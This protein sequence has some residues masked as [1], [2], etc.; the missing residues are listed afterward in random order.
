M[1]CG[2]IR[3][4]QPLRFYVESNFGHFEAPKTAILTIWAALNFEFLHIFDIFKCEI[5][6][7]SKFKAFK[8]VSMTVFDT[9]KSDNIDFT[10]NQICKKI[11]IPTYFHIV[12]YPQSKF[13]IRLLRS[14]GSVKKTLKYFFQNLKRFWI[15]SLF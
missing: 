7:K 15:F 13:L 6:K 5:L 9:L 12:E 4:F 3:I 2:N 14:S 1:Q 8:F 11:D 10:K